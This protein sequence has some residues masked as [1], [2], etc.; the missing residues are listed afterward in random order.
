MTRP[1]L[2]VNHFHGARFRYI[3]SKTF[4]A[5]VASAHADLKA[6]NPRLIYVCDPV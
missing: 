1:T 6:A 4:L 2:S 5:A 3:G